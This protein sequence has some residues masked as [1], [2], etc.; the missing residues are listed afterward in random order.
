M[1]LSIVDLAVV[2]P[3]ETPHEALLNSIELAKK[4]EVL[5][6]ERIWFSEHHGK[7]VVGRAPEI[8]VSAVA[9]Q[10][11]KIR[12]GSGSVLLNHYSPY[13]V[14]EVFC[15]LN[16]LYPGR[17]DLGIGRATTGPV[18]DLAL[19]HDKSKRF[20][21]DSDQQLQELVHWLDDSFPKDNIFSTIPIHAL[22]NRPELH[23]SGSSTWSAIASAKMGLR[24]VFAGFFNPYE[25]ANAIDVYRKNFTPAKG[26]AGIQVP[27]VRLGL[28]IVCADTEN[29]ARKQLASVQILYKRLGEGKLQFTLPTPDESVS[30][31]GGLPYFEPYIK[32]SMIPPRFLAG[33]FEQV[34]EQLHFISKDFSVDEF[35]IQDMTTDKEARYRSYEL[36]AGLL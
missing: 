13:K 5:G 21:P 2:Q 27:E 12:V 17:I 11:S 22:K 26:N 1:K 29:E 24:Y 19:Q 8:L 14:A 34:S 7:A 31:L 15:S 35:I 20:E 6:Y 23:L 28:H 30:L 16:D 25:A 32:G 4:A 10:T 18:I 3:G 9:L 36:L 33:N